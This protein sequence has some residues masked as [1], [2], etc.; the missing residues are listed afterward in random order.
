MESLFEILT[1]SMPSAEEGFFLAFNMW[2]FPASMRW[3]WVTT[4]E[5]VCTGLKATGLQCP[6]NALLHLACSSPL[7]KPSK[8]LPCAISSVFSNYKVMPAQ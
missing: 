2:Q 6:V 3:S 5:E 7:T 8:T 1:E 4:P